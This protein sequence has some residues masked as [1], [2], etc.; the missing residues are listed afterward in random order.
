MSDSTIA[1]LRLY[2]EPVVDADLESLFALRMDAMRESLARLGLTDLQHS[3]NRY[4][5]QCE[6]GAMQHIVRDGIRVGFVQLVPAEG[7]LHLIQLF[8]SPQAHGGGVG[9]WVLDW[10]KSHGQEI[11]LSAL[12]FSA[13]NRFYLRHGF[14]Q[15]GESDLDIDYRW[16]VPGASQV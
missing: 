13:A 8:L 16:S 1:P 5:S 7:Y 6:A 2:F 15:V 10:A 12:K 11:R 3:R 4:A 9:A 14:E